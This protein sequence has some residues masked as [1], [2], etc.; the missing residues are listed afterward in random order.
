MTTSRLAYLP[1]IFLFSLM[2]ADPSLA[3]GVASCPAR[4]LLALARAG[5]ACSTTERNQACYGN[6][7]VIAGFQP[8]N[9]DVS[10]AQPGIKAPISS[11]QTVTVSTDDAATADWSVAIMQLQADLLE[12]EKH[13]VT[14]HLFGDA[15]LEDLVPPTPEIQLVATGALN[16]RTR[17]ELNADIVDTVAVQRTVLANGRTS[18][19]AWLRVRVPG[20][21]EL[22]WVSHESVS[23]ELGLL[24]IV[25]FTTY[26]HRH[27]RSC[28]CVLG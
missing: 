4:V 6:G 11:L 12:G 21:N 13:S 10:F 8:G 1:F 17:P 27:F 2:I 7:S 22:G 19:G 20:T 15:Q 26:Y 25:D 23:G 3:Q 14:L 16:I 28:G 24:N 5:A 18:D 9:A